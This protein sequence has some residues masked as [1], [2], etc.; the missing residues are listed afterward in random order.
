[1]SRE[2]S[3]V[4]YQ[5]HR[6]STRF[7]VWCFAGEFIAALRLNGIRLKRTAG[8]AKGLLGNDNCEP[9]ESILLGCLAGVGQLGECGETQSCFEAMEA[10]ALRAWLD[11][12]L[13]YYEYSIGK[14]AYTSRMRAALIDSPLV[15]NVP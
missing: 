12:E 7:I 2:Y 15:G 1:M 4:V 14:P 8:K 13:P 5:Y 11:D 10:S 3:W 6:V 9:R